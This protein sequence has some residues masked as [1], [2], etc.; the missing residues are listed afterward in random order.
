MQC[1]EFEERL[2]GLLDERRSLGDDAE[3]GEHADGCEACR[4]WA[5]TL[6]EILGE[7]SARVL[8]ATDAVLQERIV[9]AVGNPFAAAIA[10]RPAATEALRSGHAFW[11]AA[12]CVLLA[13]Y[14]VWRFASRPQN[15]SSVSA[16][17]SVGASARP[18][19]VATSTSVPPTSRTT[20][21]AAAADPTLA[22]LAFAARSSY[23]VLAD[24]IRSDLNGAWEAASLAS[25]E[26]TSRPETDDGESDW[27]D[28][29]SERLKPVAES[30]V[31]TL[32]LFRS[33]LP[34]ETS[35]RS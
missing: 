8:P 21:V 35:A 30:T 11:V 22:E 3:L 13:A 4:E 14:P 19:A 20:S 31:D 25:S 16:S 18:E 28:D 24:A 27:L 32:Q 10:P 6:D 29:V 23:A 5:A 1:R 7:L 12:A 2:Q 33:V 9:A 15:I 17:A 34:A 26:A